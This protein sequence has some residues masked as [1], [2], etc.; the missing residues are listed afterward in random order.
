M[1]DSPLQIRPA[2]EADVPLVLGF[3][4][5]LADYERLSHEVVATE[6]GIR[7]GLFGPNAAAEA[8]LAHW[9]GDPAGFALYFHNFSTFAGRAGIYLED[10]Y[11]KPEHRGNG[12]G[13]ALLIHLARLARD[14]NC[15]RLEWAVL[16]WN[17][18]AIDFYRSLGALPMTEWTVNR[19]TGDALHHLADQSASR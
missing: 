9:H 4:R 1:S 13:K 16:D 6:D 14:R 11:V 10:L 19:L 5:E 2:T 3:I 17:Q 18:P 12:I 8:V 15:A 7:D